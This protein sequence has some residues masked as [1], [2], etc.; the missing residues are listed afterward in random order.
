[1]NGE[2]KK[3]YRKYLLC[4]FFIIAGSFLAIRFSLWG[5]EEIQA[6]HISAS[7]FCFIFSLFGFLFGCLSIAIFKFNRNAFLKIENNQIDAQFGLDKEIHIE[8]IDIIRVE[9]I[10]SNLILF[11]DSDIIKINDLSNANDINAYISSL[12]PNYV[13]EISAEE[14]KA[15]LQKSRKSFISYL[16]A[17]IVVCALLFINIVWCV[18]LTNSKELYDFSRSDDLI[19]LAFTFAEIITV[20]SAF[21]LA[22]ICGKKLELYNMNKERFNIK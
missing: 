14:A 13:P 16:V 1:M 6:N 8:I 11:T 2:F 17:T 19:F 20:S 22:S 18:L 12:I 4:L 5:I 10:G 9:N 7:V 15:R 21:I 3:T